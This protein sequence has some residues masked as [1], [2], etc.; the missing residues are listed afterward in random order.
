MKD[1][2]KKKILDKKWARLEHTGIKRPTTPAENLK[3]IREAH[4]GA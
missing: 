4:V 3:R 1:K 2:I